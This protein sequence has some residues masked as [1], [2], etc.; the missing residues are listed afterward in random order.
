MTSH[1]LAENDRLRGFERR[2]SQVS[3]RHLTSEC[4]QIPEKR[5]DRRTG[6]GFGEI[7]L[8]DR[9]LIRAG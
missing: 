5:H 1:R 4:L 2:L 3:P 6:P 8:V 7:D 9:Y